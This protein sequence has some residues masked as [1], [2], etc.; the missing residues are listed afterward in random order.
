MKT[1]LNYLVLALL[2]M[3]ALVLSSCAPAA[4][5]T[6]TPAPTK[7]ATL[8]PTAVPTVVPTTPPAKKAKVLMLL[9]GPLGVNPYLV[10]GK[11]GFD[12]AAKD[13]G[14]E[15][16][17][18][19][20][21]ND[22]AQ[23]ADNLRAASREDW[24]LIV[25]MTYGFADA[26]TEV[27]PQTPNKAYVCVDCAVSASNVLNIGFKTHE[28]SF[29]EGAVAG[30]LTKSN[31][32]GVVG[33]MDVPF[34][35]RWTDAFGA[36][37]K[38]VNPN[39]KVLET[40]WVGSY[41]DPAKAKELALALADQGADHINAAAAAGNPG[42]FEAAKERGFFTYGVDINECPKAPGFVAESNIKRVDLAIYNSIRDFLDGKFSGGFADLSL[43]D[44]GV[45][46][47]TFAYPNSDTSCVLGKYPEVVAKVKDLRAKI[48]SGELKVEDP[49]AQQ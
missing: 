30:Y 28:N 19:E 46:L 45:D 6:P 47:A 5:P 1:R 48:I 29:L 18:T 24:D 34:I 22:T 8:A 20:G 12:K 14:I 43:A 27:A 9:E 39:V 36:G 42:I 4:T 17:F 35:H 49:L 37:A 25:L 15:T 3:V 44:G 16:R 13:F 26:L 11:E 31:I 21:A 32:V 7:A 10:N 41:G 2:T 33:P 40:L 23:N 38:Y